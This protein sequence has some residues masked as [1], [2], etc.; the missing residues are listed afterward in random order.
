MPYTSNPYAAKARRLAVNDVIYRGLS[1]AEAGRRYGVTKSAVCKWMKKAHPDHRVFIHTIPSRPYSHPRQLDTHIVERIVQLRRE[2]KR[3]APIIHAHLLQEGIQVSLSSVART[4]KRQRLLLRKKQIKPYIS[5]PR[6]EVTAPGNLVQMDTIHFVKPDK[7]RF[8]IYALI[9]T[10]TRIAYAEYH[11]HI[12][13]KTSFEVVQRAQKKFG[14]RFRVVQTDHGA[15]FSESFSH[16]L[17]R[18]QILLR[19]SRIRKP[20]DNAFIERFNRTIQEEC[21]DGFL[22]K[23]KYISRQLTAYLA[24]YNTKRLHLSLN[25]LTPIQFFK[26]FPRF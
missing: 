12:S 22:P 24:F 10:Y 3:C 21:F 7:S 9:D 8:Y 13:H 5:I 11:P 18:K 15:E 20:N 1:L 26:S 16:L 25:C 4:L 23:E 14:F 19:H 17:N 6:P 2:L